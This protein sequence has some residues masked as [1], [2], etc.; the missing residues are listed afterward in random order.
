MKSLAHS[1]RVVAVLA[2][3]VL[4][5][6]ASTKMSHMWRDPSY[7]SGPLNKLLVVAVRTDQ[8]RRKIWED[9]FVAALARQGVNAT[10]SYRLI[11]ETLPDTGRVNRIAREGKFDGVVLV[12]RV[13]RKTTNGVTASLDVGPTNPSSHAWNG[14]EYGFSDHDYY[15]G[16]PIEDETVKDEIKVWA[17]GGGGRMIW[18]GVGELNDSDREEDV[19]DQI[20]SLIVP[21]LLTEGVIAAGV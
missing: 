18:I 11:A 8:A 16:Y 20:I 12:G 17:T 1:H 6:C 3:V 5:S 21:Q 7:T 10:P 15:P 19:S 9:A 4:S 14:W 13:S 2:L